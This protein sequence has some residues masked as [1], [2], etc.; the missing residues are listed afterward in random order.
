MSTLKDLEKRQLEDLLG[1]A[2]GYVLDYN[3]A[4]FSALFRETVNIDINSERYTKKGE[5]KAKRMRAFWEIESDAIVGKLLAELLQVWNYYNSPRNTEKDSVCYAAC[6]VSV[7][8]LSGVASRD[9][10]AET[11]FLRKNF[12][13]ESLNKLPLDAMM[14]QILRSR[15]SEAIQCLQHDAPLAVVILCGSILEGM[16]LGVASRRIADFNGSASAPKDKAGKL[17]AIHDWKLFQLIDA[18]HDIG[19]LSL[20]VKKFGHVLRD[21]RNYIHPQQQICC[22]FHPD[23]HT[24]Q[25]CLQVL[26]AATASLAGLR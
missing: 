16:L 26:R 19:L 5:S 18:A 8:R 17:M 12:G 14:L 22:K 15:Y 11:V 25:I 6:K 10:D 9:D 23:K 2:N 21:F 4:T 1:M 3:N 24:A 13:E 20:D 7:E